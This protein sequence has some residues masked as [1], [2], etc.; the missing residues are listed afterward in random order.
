MGNFHYYSFLSQGVWRENSKLQ[1]RDNRPISKNS[2]IGRTLS[3]SLHPLLYLTNRLVYLDFSLNECVAVPVFIGRSD[4]IATTEERRWEI[5]LT[6]FPCTFTNLPPQG[7]I[8]FKV[9]KVKNLISRL[10]SMVFR[11]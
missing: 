11:R 5:K 9:N 1:F 2:R 10:H 6:Q 8:H 3:I 7:K 4:S